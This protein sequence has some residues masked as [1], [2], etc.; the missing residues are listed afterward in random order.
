[1]YRLDQEKKY[2]FFEG[3]KL[4][5]RSVEWNLVGFCTLCEGELWSIAYY[6]VF[7]GWMVAARCDGC[8]KMVL[9]RFDKSWSWEGDYDLEAAEPA[10]PTGDASK[11]S[12]ISRLSREELETVFTPAELRDME[13]CERG[14]AY[15][16]QNLYRARA[17]Y[18]KFERLFGV[19]LDI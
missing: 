17:K 7:E 4:E 1:M 10:P 3:Q 2:L 13:R 14:E 16:R 18:E 6:Q 11:A 8:D 19:K 12:S 5:P 15:T 9:A